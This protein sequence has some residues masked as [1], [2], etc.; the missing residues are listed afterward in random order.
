[1]GYVC[2]KELSILIVG[3]CKEEDGSLEEEEEGIVEGETISAG[4]SLNSV[5]GIDN[6]RTMK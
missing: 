1:M 6:P 2:K 5:V 4:I 3:E